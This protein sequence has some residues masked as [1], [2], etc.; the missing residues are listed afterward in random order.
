[1][2]RLLLTPEPTRPDGT[3]C[4]VRT[5]F[6]DISVTQDQPLVGDASKWIHWVLAQ[7]PGSTVVI[8]RT[9]D[10]QASRRFDTVETVIG[11]ARVV[12]GQMV[13]SWEGMA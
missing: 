2:I 3:S 4:P 11:T 13:V 5:M 8:R 12:D 9:A 1:M 10:L 6:A 7:H